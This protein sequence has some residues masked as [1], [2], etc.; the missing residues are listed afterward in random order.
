[1]SNQNQVVKSL[2][3]TYVLGT[4]KRDESYRSFISIQVVFGRAN[5]ILIECNIV[6]MRS[7]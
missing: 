2:P 3:I 4:R 1:M 6:S 5:I 7:M